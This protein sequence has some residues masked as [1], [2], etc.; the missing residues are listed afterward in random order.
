SS[1][2]QNPVGVGPG[3]GGRG[4]EEAEPFVKLHR[5]PDI[6]RFQADLVKLPEHGLSARYTS[7]DGSAASGASRS[8]TQLHVGPS[9]AVPRNQLRQKARVLH[10]RVER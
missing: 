3:I 10:P 1:I 2:G 6:D 4:L 7:S 8:P 9:L 5:C